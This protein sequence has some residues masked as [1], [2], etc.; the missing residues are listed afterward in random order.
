VGAKAE[1]LSYPTTTRQRARCHN[2]G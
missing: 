1:W 2:E